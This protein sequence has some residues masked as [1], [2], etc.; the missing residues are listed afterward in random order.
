MIYVLLFITFCLTR[1]FI[2]TDL[3][4]KL[5]LYLGWYEHLIPLPF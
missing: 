5:M 4:F 3:S 2:R 1:K